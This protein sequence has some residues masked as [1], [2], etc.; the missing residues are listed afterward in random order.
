M[1]RVRRG[2][3]DSSPRVRR[4]V[5]TDR[6][7]VRSGWFKPILS[8]G[9][10]NRADRPTGVQAFDSIVSVVFACPQRVSFVPTKNKFSGS[11]FKCRA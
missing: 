9:H 10:L 6:L 4:R 3:T 11:K 5:I 7:D 2:S 8:F 1:A